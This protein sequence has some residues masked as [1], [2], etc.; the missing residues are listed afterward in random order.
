MAFDEAELPD[1]FDFDV[2]ELGATGL[3]VVLRF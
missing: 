3:N 2:D 1:L